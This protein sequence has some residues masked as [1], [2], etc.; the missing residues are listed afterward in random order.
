MTLK[1]KLVLGFMAIA[2][3]FAGG[4]YSVSKSIST[5]S[6]IN[7]EEQRNRNSHT[8][9]T[10][11]T[12]KEP[13]G[14]VKIVTTTD[15]VSSVEITK[16]EDTIT[17]SVQAPAKRSM[18]NISLLAGT[19]VTHGLAVIQTYGISISKEVFGPITAGLWGMTSGTAGISIGLNF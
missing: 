10:T 14:Q 8:Q 11:V 15:T 3:A 2:L 4:R 19:D 6:E 9:T 16:K 1:G 17:K 18:I 7:T 5:E 13:S 12:T